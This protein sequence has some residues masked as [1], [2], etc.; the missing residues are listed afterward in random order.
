MAGEKAR[1]MATTP[2]E[3]VVADARE[4]IAGVTERRGGIRRTTMIPGAPDPANQNGEVDKTI[5]ISLTHESGRA[6]FRSPSI[7][8]ADNKVD[9]G[10]RVTDRMPG[11]KP[12]FDLLRDEFKRRMGII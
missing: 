12:L 11:R 8:V 10:D 4:E 1:E 6:G 5:F 9:E 7:K 3:T 2:D